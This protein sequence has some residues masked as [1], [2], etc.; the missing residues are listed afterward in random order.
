MHNKRNYE[1]L[2][3]YEGVRGLAVKVLNRVDRT[4]AYLDK[5]LDIEFRNSELSGLDKALLFE[6]VHGVIRWLG[7]IDWILTGFYKGQFSKCIP[8]VKN[9]MRVALYQILFLDKVPDYAAVNEAVEFVKKLQGQKSADQTNAVLR[10]IIRTKDA[11]RYPNPKED[12]ASYYSAYYSHP[13]WLVRR[14]IKR[15]G[16]EA[17]EQLL[18]SNN[19]RPNLT[20]R[21]NK[22]K[23][24]KEELY[25]LLKSVE[26][27]FT[28]GRYINTYLR[29]NQLTN[30]TDW[31]YFGDGYFT[32]QDESTGFPCQLL[33]VKPGMKVLDFCAAPGG[34]TGILAEMMENTGEL[35]AL[36]KFASRLKILKKNLER[37]GVTNMTAVESDA[38]EF[39]EDGFDRILVDAPCSGLGTLT[40]K[41]DIKWKR[42]TS[43]IRNLT[44]IQYELL[45]K[46]ATLVKIGGAVVYSTCTIEPD[47]NFKIIEK[48]LF[49][50]PNFSLQNADQFVNKS[51]VDETGCVQTLPHVHKIDG[52]FAAKIIRNE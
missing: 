8:N 17:A 40:K 21:I 46:A 18:M 23:S 13:A 6:I 29:M 4:D 50:H 1:E 20:I 25:K 33:D 16:D 9:A 36:D 44:A 48:F 10:N 2:K 32:I 42:D 34:K 22:L 47:E 14:W 26:L 7:R 38:R 11:I 30:I 31:K 28:E 19:D 39:A 5:M 45:E 41:P 37:L 27:G 15:Y 49:E 3:L 43:D 51:V 12:L 24:S 52:S 35:Y